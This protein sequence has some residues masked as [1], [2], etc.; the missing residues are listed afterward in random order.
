MALTESEKTSGVVCG[1]LRLHSKADAGG[2][3]R[4]CDLLGFLTEDRQVQTA[5]HFEVES[6]FYGDANLE[7]GDWQVVDAVVDKG[8]EVGPKSISAG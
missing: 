6:E 1:R 4:I 3:R 5:V 8:M 7:L 2:S